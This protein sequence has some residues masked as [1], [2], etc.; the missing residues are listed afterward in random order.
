MVNGE[1]F[2]PH[3]CRSGQQ[4][5]FNG[6]DLSDGTGKWLRIAS[7][8]DN[9][10]SVVVFE[11]GV[12]PAAIVGC[13]TLHLSKSARD[14]RG[15]YKVSGDATMACSGDGVSVTGSVFFDDCGLAY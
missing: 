12:R 7:N 8:V 5:E 14:K 4:E 10:V 9:S 15:R 13:T 1:R 6:V 2:G 11:P 3:E